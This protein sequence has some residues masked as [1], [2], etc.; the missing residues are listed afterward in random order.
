MSAYTYVV[1]DQLITRKPCKLLSLTVSTQG[2]GPGIVKA[3]NSRGA[4]SADLAVNVLCPANQS[5]QFAF[6]GLEF[7]KGLFV[8]IVEKADYVTV[9][10]KHIEHQ[11]GER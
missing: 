11:S 3:Y 1:T 6:H 2:G 9:E 7:G 8:E 5:K 10:W 4:V